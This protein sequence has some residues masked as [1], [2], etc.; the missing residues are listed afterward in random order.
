MFKLS[1]YFGYEKQF[2]ILHSITDLSTGN[3]GLNF[4]FKGE[5]PNLLGSK[6][7]KY[8]FKYNVSS[9]Y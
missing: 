5:I 7:S 6:N 4:V 1:Y 9:Y 3:I 2:Y 8:S